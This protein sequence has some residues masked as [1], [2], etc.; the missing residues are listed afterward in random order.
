MYQTKDNF[1]L[2]DEFAIFVQKTSERKIVLEH[3]LQITGNPLKRFLISRTSEPTNVY[4]CHVNKET[5]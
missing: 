1:L 4:L 5:S 3:H 2:F